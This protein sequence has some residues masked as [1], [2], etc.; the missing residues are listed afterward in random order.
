MELNLNNPTSPRSLN[1]KKEVSQRAFWE[2]YL[3]LVN[4]NN[5]FLSDRE[6]DV[7]SYILTL[8]AD[9]SVFA[10]GNNQKIAKATGMS[11]QQ[12]TSVKNSLM[13]KEFLVGEI[14]L[15][16][17]PSLRNF[18]K[19]IQKTKETDFVFRFPYKLKW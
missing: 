15:M 19:Y 1:I 7:L 5:P 16:P 2:Y 17:H 11:S 10:R 8:N 9:K 12:L 4:I 6:I 14:D 13:E 3:K 18:Q